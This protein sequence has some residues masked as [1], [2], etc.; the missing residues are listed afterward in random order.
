MFT[1]AI[2]P[3]GNLKINAS[4]AGREWITDNKDRGYWSLMA[5][6]FEPWSCN[7]SY[8]HF[9][10]GQANPCV[11]LTSAPCIAESMDV[12]DQ[13]NCSVVGKLWHLNNYMIQDD[14][15]DLCQKGFVEYQLVH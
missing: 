5:D 3:N 2:E 12:D 4:E 8:N 6:I 7:G 10:A 9:D 15:E 11:G 14:L 13:G 1:I